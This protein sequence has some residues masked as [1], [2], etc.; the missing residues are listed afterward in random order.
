MMS[1]VHKHSPGFDTNE[2]T[3]EIA[4]ALPLWYH[5][6]A[7][8]GVS[9]QN[10]GQRQRCLR[11]THGVQTVGQGIEILERLQSDDH[12]PHWA[13]QCEPCVRDRDESG[14]QNPHA[15]AKTVA[16]RLG[17]IQTKW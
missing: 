7:K 4:N 10:N 15:C 11:E 16:A 3:S 12:S 13:C 14:C 17:Q 1:A 8:A 2:P 9:Q 6:G 5:F